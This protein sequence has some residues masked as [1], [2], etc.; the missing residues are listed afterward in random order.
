MK[1]LFLVLSLCFSLCLVGCST[2]PVEV[3]Q[4]EVEEVKEVVSEEVQTEFDFNT[5]ADK[6]ITYTDTLNS[7]MQ[8]IIDTYT[9]DSIVE[10]Y[11]NI[12]EINEK[13]ASMNV[14]ALSNKDYKD[15]V[16]YLD[17]YKLIVV[18]LSDLI[19]KSYDKTLSKDQINEISNLANEAVTYSNTCN[20]Y[21][22]VFEKYKQ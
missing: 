15:A 20:T 2:A 19:V 6:Y 7:Y 12:K 4:E 3:E 9:N 5:F 14:K 16:D 13:T 22:N 17:S 18:R 21:A 1:K 8:I 10:S 11:Y